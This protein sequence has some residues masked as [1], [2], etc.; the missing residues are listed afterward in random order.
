MQTI[1][2]IAIVVV[3]A[4]PVVLSVGWHKT[5]V[6][7]VQAMGWFLLAVTPV[8][9]LLCI[10]A[11]GEPRQVET[12]NRITLKDYWTMIARPSLLRVLAA[13]LFLALGPAIT[14]VLYLFFFTQRWAS[15]GPRPM[16]CC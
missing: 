10:A 12:A 15:R 3:L 11:V 6:Q 16:P 14:A 4:L 5:I 1:G 2:V 7:G 13:D 8:T 9:V